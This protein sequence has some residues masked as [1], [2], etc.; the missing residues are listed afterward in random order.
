MFKISNEASL[1][2]P[3][4]NIDKISMKFKGLKRHKY[5]SSILLNKNQFLLFRR[6]GDLL[7]ADNQFQE[8]KFHYSVHIL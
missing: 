8:S 3:Q 6:H 1:I 7:F 4:N 2:N 5:K